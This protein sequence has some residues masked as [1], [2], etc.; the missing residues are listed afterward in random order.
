M[1]PRFQKFSSWQCVLNMT[2]CFETH[3]HAKSIS[4][5]I[6][7]SVR[8]TQTLILFKNLKLDLSSSQQGPQLSLTFE[9][10]TTLIST[11]AWI[12]AALPSFSL[13]RNLTDRTISIRLIWL[14]SFSIF[15]KSTLSH[16]GPAITVSNHYAPTKPV[17][18]SWVQ[19]SQIQPQN[20]T[21]I[22]IAIN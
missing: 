3:C 14:Q 21:L 13:L 15:V 19:G 7:F 12:L 6:M 10:A 5:L 8:S 18:R 1:G 9:N 11:M 17:V 22:V 2:V 16:S 20:H 4:Q